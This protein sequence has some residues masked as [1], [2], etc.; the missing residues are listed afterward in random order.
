MLLCDSLDGKVIRFKSFYLLMSEPN[1][2]LWVQ[3]VS[4][5][6][7]MCF[8]LIYVPL[9]LN[10]SLFKYFTEV[11]EVSIFITPLL[12]IFQHFNKEKKINKAA[13]CHIFILDF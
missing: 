11:S 3:H 7:W 12:F 8:W 2:G 6:D 1:S 13:K 9:Y 10:D 4:D 5:D